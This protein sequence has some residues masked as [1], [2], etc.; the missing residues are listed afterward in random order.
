MS[1][2]A[3]F[4][5][6]IN[7]SGSILTILA[8]IISFP[9]LT[10]LLSAN[11]YG[12]M[13]LLS[14]TILLCVGF[15]KL[16]IQQALVR[17]WK[18]DEKLNLIA[19]STAFYGVLI[20]S[21]A[22]VVITLIILSFYLSNLRTGNTL[23][24]ALVAGII[25]IEAL[26]SILINKE[27]ALEKTV[28]FNIAKVFHKYI[29][30]LVAIALLMT[31]NNG[32][33]DIFIGFYTASVI[34]FA[35][36]YVSDK[37]MVPSF[38]L[39]D[40]KLLKQMTAFGFPLLLVEIIDQALS[41][42]DRYLIAYFLDFAAVGQYSAAYGLLVNVQSVVI[43]TLS[44]TIGPIVVRIYNEKGDSGVQAFLDQSL[45][46]YCCI[47]SAIALGLFAVGP[48]IFILLA[49]SRYELAVPLLKPIAAAYFFY[50]IY[51]IAAYT[52]F[53]HKRTVL[54]AMIMAAAAVVSI[55]GNIILLPKIGVMGAAIS[56]LMAYATL[57]I[58]G[59]WLMWRV[60]FLM[61][62]LALIP[63]LLPSIVMYG[64]LYLLP[65][66]RD[67]MSVGYR[68][69]IGCTIWALI[70]AL[71]YKDARVSLMRIVNI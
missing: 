61:G 4:G 53:I 25:L 64:T 26:K 55:T 34:I 39:F 19:F 12:L 49:S 42:S 68:V 20:I 57:A 69:F 51:I 3:I 29:Y 67:W 50:G 9:L 43:S 21:I 46:N 18:P 58:I 13:S 17:L 31:I 59:C 48:D 14:T 23:L 41:F 11:D 27:F 30:I 10:R 1:N 47:G 56:I 71:C 63:H 15:S 28:R 66:S 22:V 8:G 70:C 6:F 7:S 33:D 54:A 44:L 37:K 24:L 52:L 32:V 62:I 38:K 2:K 36:L 35:W 16:G 45:K 60:R 40:A 5:A 65:A